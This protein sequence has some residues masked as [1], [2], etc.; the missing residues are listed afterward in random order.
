MFPVHRT[1][2]WCFCWKKF[3]NKIQSVENAM[4][5]ALSV[6][7]VGGKTNLISIYNTFLCNSQKSRDH[8]EETFYHK[9]SAGWDSVARDPTRDFGAIWVLL[10]KTNRE[11]YYWNIYTLK[12][13]RWDL[14]G[15]SPVSGLGETTP[16]Y[17]A[18]IHTNCTF[19]EVL[20][21]KN[22]TE[23]SCLTQP[24]EKRYVDRDVAVKK[25]TG[26]TVILNLDE[27]HR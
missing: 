3:L 13:M 24:H 15:R 16:W 1:T 23:E 14:G 9:S 21:A 12:S 22:N 11:N 25:L 20:H 2:H 4:G 5:D 10:F 17:K 8:S 26:T 27:D 18:R 19:W 7:L 6:V